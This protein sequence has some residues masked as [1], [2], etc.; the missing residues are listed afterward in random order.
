[1]ELSHLFK[2][3]LLL[4]LIIVVA[5][6]TSHA[7]LKKQSSSS[8]FNK[9]QWTMRVT[10]PRV[11]P[12]VIARQRYVSLASPLATLSDRINQVTQVFLDRELEIWGQC[13]I[14][15]EQYYTL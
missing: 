4:L 12:L 1:L 13:D 5:L 15:R 3:I 9:F 14:H 8:L 2:S 7:E 11:F 6:V 10:K